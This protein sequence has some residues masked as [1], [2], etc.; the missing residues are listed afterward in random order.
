MMSIPTTKADQI[1]FTKLFAQRSGASFAAVLNECFTTQD[2]MRL[3]NAQNG[4]SL[5]LDEA[6][7]L[8]VVRDP[9]A[10]FKDEIDKFASFAWHDVFL[11]IQARKHAV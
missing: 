3:F 10:D 5:H 9:I 1:S 4:T 7:R 2:L 6:T 8:V 11:Q